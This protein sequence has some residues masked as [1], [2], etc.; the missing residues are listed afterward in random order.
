LAA[1]Q[2]QYVR[3][4]LYAD[5]AGRYTIVAIV[6]R[7]GQR[8]SVHAHYTWS[9]AAV[10]RGELTETIYRVSRGAAP[11]FPV[12]NIKRRPGDFTF[13]WPLNEIHHVGNEGSETAIS[14]HVYGVGCEW[15][16]TGVNRF[17][18]PADVSRENA[19]RTAHAKAKP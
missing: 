3:H 4:I 12:S 2:E 7:P 1:G 17:I 13:H 15:L 14:I 10:Y 18:A 8:S 11:P 19:R 9:G 5:A 16:A 6:W